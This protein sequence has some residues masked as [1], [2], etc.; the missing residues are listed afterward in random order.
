MVGWFDE[1]MG[2]RCRMAK[3]KPTGKK[4]QHLSNSKKKRPGG[5]LCM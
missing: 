1:P 2:L 5:F 3:K 4:K